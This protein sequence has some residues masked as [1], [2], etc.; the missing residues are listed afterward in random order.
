[1]RVELKALENRNALAGDPHGQAAPIWARLDTI[2][3]TLLGRETEERLMEAVTQ[4]ATQA[5]NIGEI[6]SF[7]EALAA[8]VRD[9]PDSPRSADFK[10]ALQEAPLWIGLAKWNEWLTQIRANN[11]TT[12]NAA[13]AKTLLDAARP[14][15][16]D[17]G[18]YPDAEA[19]R[20][21]VPYLEAVTQ[22]VDSEQRSIVEPVKRLFKDPLMVDLWMIETSD[23]RRFYLQKKP[24]LPLDH[25]ISV[26]C[27]TGFD[28]AEKL[29]GFRPLSADSIKQQVAAPQVA[30]GKAA[31]RL[32]ADVNDENWESTFVQVAEIIIKDRETEPILKTNLLKQ[33]LDAGCRGSHVLE[34][35]FKPQREAIDDA[36]VDPAA[37]WLDPKDGDA[38]DSRKKAETLFLNLPGIADAKQRVDSELAE[39]RKPVGTRVRWVGWLR[40]GA[41]GNWRCDPARLGSES[42]NL[43]A[44]VPKL[45]GGGLT[46]EPIGKVERGIAEVDPAA[47]RSLVEGRPVYLAAP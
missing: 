11:P 5:G 36:H 20:R 26:L 2:E 37:N 1:M 38:A 13:A 43:L 19:V 21:L 24:D 23:G 7:R 15:L 3:A 17:Y 6:E 45:I 10:R 47:G 18:G 46:L 35:A 8:Y 31:R 33:T 30:L 27:L 44:P 32:L 39:L 28:L 34:L 9:L 41:K 40:R 42:G 4:G 22:R 29:H 25:S 14:V 12:L 16:K